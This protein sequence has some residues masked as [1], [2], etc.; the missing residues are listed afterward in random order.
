MVHSSMRKQ[1]RKIGLTFMLDY[2][3]IFSAAILLFGNFLEN[4]SFS[5]RPLRNASRYVG[6]F[7]SIGNGGNGLTVKGLVQSYNFATWHRQPE[8]CCAGFLGEMANS[9]KRLTEVARTERLAIGRINRK[10]ARQGIGKSIHISTMFVKRS[11]WPVRKNRWG[12]CSSAAGGIIHEGR[13]EGRRETGSLT[14]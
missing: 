7:T 12:N 13:E 1:G 8:G 9:G 4:F 2:E 5:R 10:R 11:F 14:R 3:G 6:K